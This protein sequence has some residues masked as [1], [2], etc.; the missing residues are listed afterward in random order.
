MTQKQ[1]D[2]TQAV[3][4]HD[5]LFESCF[6]KRFGLPLEEFCRAETNT[7][8]QSHIRLV[9]DAFSCVNGIIMDHVIAFLEACGKDTPANRAAARLL[10][11]DLSH[12]HESAN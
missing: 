4:A 8:T 5:T 10:M 12:T 1:I 2:L 9:K 11:I 3:K 7:K 6:E